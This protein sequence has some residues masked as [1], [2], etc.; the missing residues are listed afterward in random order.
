DQL[1]ELVRYKFSH[2]NCE[3]GQPAKAFLCQNDF[4]Y[5][6]RNLDMELLDD[7]EKLLNQPDYNEME[8]LLIL[9]LRGRSIHDIAELKGTYHLQRNEL[10]EA[11]KEYQ[12][13]PADY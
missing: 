6:R 7:M 2:L 8:K 3:A 11:V 4:E 9:N 5:L 12:R 13:L 10:T 1:M